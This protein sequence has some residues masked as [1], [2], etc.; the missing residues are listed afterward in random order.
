MALM[1]TT[2]CNLDLNDRQQIALSAMIRYF[3]QPC[4]ELRQQGIEKSDLYVY[5]T[6]VTEIKKMISGNVKMVSTSSSCW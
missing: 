5:E 2:R 4:Q 6:G 3:E 1:T